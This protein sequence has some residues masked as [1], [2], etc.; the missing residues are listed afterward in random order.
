M[1]QF[2][3]IINTVDAHTAGEPLRIIT[4][5]FPAVKGKTILE[6]RRCVKENYDHLRKMLMLEPRGHSGMYGCLLTEPATEDGDYGVIFMHNEGYSTMC[7]HGIIAVTKV[8]V[9]SGMI[10]I[11]TGETKVE[12][13]IDSPAGRITAWAEVKN[14]KVGKVGFY[15]VPSFVYKEDL[16]V[17]V[18]GVG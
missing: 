12:L 4:S 16:A 7:G 13:K 11:A 2:S 14:G 15:N 3:R 6:K 1:L 17:P 8:A 9:E 18:G 10:Y 5:G